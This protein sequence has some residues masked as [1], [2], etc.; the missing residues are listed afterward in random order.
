MARLRDYQIA[1]AQRERDV[2][3]SFTMQ[4]AMKYPLISRLKKAPKPA[5]NIMEWPLKTFEDPRTTGVADGV[6][7]TE[8]DIENNQ[9]NRTMLANR[10][11]RIWRIPGVSRIANRV[12]SQ[13]GVQG[14][15]QQ[16]NIKDKMLELW[17][18]F[19]ATIKS[20]K[21][22]V[23][24]AAGPTASLMRGISRWASNDAGS[25]T[26]TPTTP[27]SAY[28]CPA[29][30]I[31]G[32]KAAA[33]NVTE[34][35]LLQVMVDMASSRKEEQ[36]TIGL[37]TALMRLRADK[38]TRTDENVSA[39]T[40]PV[41]RFDQKKEG[42]VKFEVKVFRSSAGALTLFSDYYMPLD[43]GAALIH[44]LIINPD[45]LEIGTVEAPYYT[46][47]EDRGGGPRGIA[48]ATFTLECLAP[49][50]LGVIKAGAD[51]AR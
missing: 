1:D 22:S 25:F 35:N 6:D 18:D 2:R 40:S 38:F 48:E 37:C 19:E 21:E 51:G 7:I 27:A 31:L 36:E 41:V 28:R 15:A 43:T 10:Y 23:A 50:G 17:R 45:L 26:D 3:P 47:L 11:Q 42:E 32:G 20:D 8:S 33:T 30:H 14:T 4:I 29:A 16:D 44:M 9:S 5:S 39:S 24:S 13:Y 49:N 12:I 34:D 46:A